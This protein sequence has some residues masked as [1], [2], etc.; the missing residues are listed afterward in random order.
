MSDAYVGQVVSVAF[1]F[2]PVDW[3]PCDG[4]LVNISDYETLFTLIGTTYG[5]DG[6]TQFALP[7]LSGT[8]AVGAGTGPN[9][10]SYSVGQAGGAE[11]VTLTAAQLPAHTHPMFASGTTGTTN[12]PNADSLAAYSG[13]DGVPYSTATP[14]IAMSTQALLPVAGG[15]QPHENRQPLLCLNYIIAMQGLFP[16]QG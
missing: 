2:A 3:L 14:S 15:G 1:D 10:S 9:L 6:V 16:P 5:G 8:V 13:Q 4:R 11:T 12:T 7:N